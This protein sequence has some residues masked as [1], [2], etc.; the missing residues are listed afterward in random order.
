MTKRKRFVSCHHSSP[1]FTSEHK[2]FTWFK[3]H[4]KQPEGSR[5]TTT[6]I[7]YTQGWPFWKRRSCCAEGLSE[8]GAAASDRRGTQNTPWGNTQRS[9]GQAGSAHPSTPNLCRSLTWE[10]SLCPQW[11]LP[12]LKENSLN[13][14]VAPTCTHIP[15]PPWQTWLPGGSGRALILPSCRRAAPGQSRAISKPNSAHLLLVWLIFLMQDS[16][17]LRLCK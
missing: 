11:F 2:I 10:G 9:R 15:A 4:H 17:R 16:S 13:V 12:V 14:V 3:I 5:A 6:L 8:F 1:P 7:N